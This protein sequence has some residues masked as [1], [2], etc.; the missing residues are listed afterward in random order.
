MKRVEGRR[1]Y[2]EK[3]WQNWEKKKECKES[4]FFLK[5]IRRNKAD[6]LSLV[7]LTPLDSVCPITCSDSEKNFF[8]N[9][10]AINDEFFFNNN[11][12]ML[13]A[14]MFS[15]IYPTAIGSRCQERRI[16]KFINCCSKP[17]HG[18]FLLIACLFICYFRHYR[19]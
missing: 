15:Q 11:D 6:S 1:H 2:K 9:H 17:W 14:S 12:G 19:T 5:A 3:W 10:D 7:F 8:F 4:F 16:E 13:Q 18:F